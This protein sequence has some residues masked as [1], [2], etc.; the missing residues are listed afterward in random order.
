MK[1]TCWDGARDSQQVPKI[2]QRVN[3][4]MNG[5]GPAVV[6]GYFYSRSSD[7]DGL[8][9]VGVMTLPENPPQW[10]KDQ[11]LRKGKQRELAPEWVLQGIGCE[12]GAEIDE[13]PS[14]PKTVENY[15]K[16]LRFYAGLFREKQWQTDFIGA[17][18]FAQTLEEIGTWIEKL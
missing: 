14:S 16:N 4:V 1:G 6:K 3:I 5:I 10:L 7:W 17:E 9:W 11:V 12:F 13:L 15:I 2:G 18:V 8:G